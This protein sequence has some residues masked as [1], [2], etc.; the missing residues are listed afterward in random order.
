MIK[1]YSIT[2]GR[3]IRREVSKETLDRTYHKLNPFEH[4]LLKKFSFRT[5]NEGDEASLDLIQLV[6]YNGDLTTS[7]K[8]EVIGA[9]L[10][11]EF[12]VDYTRY[13]VH[14]LP[15]TREGYLNACEDNP[16]KF[17]FDTKNQ[18][19]G[20]QTEFTKEEIEE[21]KKCPELKG[22]NFDECLEEVL[23]EDGD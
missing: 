12:T 10:A 16:G 19:E 3:S 13:Y 14:V 18:W 9:I 6:S 2:N 5:K 20:S 1:Y 23:E 11:G 15:G 4:E 7:R 22:I 17:Y 8:L 21:L